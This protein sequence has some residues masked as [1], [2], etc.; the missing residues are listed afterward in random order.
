MGEETR[1]GEDG[2]EEGEGSRH[3]IGPPLFSLRV[4]VLV[5]VFIEF[6]W[7]KKTEREVSNIYTSIVRWN[8]GVILNA[9]HFFP[10]EPQ[11]HSEN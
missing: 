7:T 4:G 8:G 3:G 10:S 11:F 5:Y 6:F 1:G 9:H 2:G